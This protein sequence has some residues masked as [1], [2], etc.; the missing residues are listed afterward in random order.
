[1]KPQGYERA[2][3]YKGLRAR[4]QYPDQRRALP[5]AGKSTGSTETGGAPAGLASYAAKLDL[6]ASR[7]DSRQAR[8]R[9]VFLNVPPTSKRPNKN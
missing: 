5:S 4:R 6:S 1:V 2:L 3:G 7:R 8:P 9:P